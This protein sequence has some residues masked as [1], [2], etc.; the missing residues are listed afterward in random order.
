MHIINVLHSTTF[1]DA[2]TH[3]HI[4]A[5]TYTHTHIHASHIHT[6]DTHTHTLMCTHIHKHIMLLN[7]E[8]QLNWQEEKISDISHRNLRYKSDLVTT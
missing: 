8:M 5:H 3:A 6:Y 7:I 2:L 4:C 1:T